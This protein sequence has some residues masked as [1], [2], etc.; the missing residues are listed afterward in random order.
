MQNAIIGDDNSLVGGAL[1]AVVL[2][3][4]NV[5]MDRLSFLGPNMEWLFE[6]RPTTLITDGKVDYAALRRIGLREHEL[7][8]ALRKQQADATSEVALAQL[9]PGGTFRIELKRVEQDASTGELAEA[10]ARI[11]RHIDERL[12]RLESRIPLRDE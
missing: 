11:E 7:M 4:F 2:V 6:G 10:V 3:G 8:T 12:T 1:G 5:V 9:Q